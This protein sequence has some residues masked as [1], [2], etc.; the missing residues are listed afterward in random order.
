[1]KKILLL[2][3]MSA[4]LTVTA[5]AQRQTEDSFCLSDL[6]TNPTG[7]YFDVSLRGSR[8]YT[9]YNLDIFLPLG[10]NVVKAQIVT[11]SAAV[12]PATEEEVWDD[13][14]EENPCSEALHG[15]IIQQRGVPHTCL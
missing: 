1:M 2:F 14:Q 15:A 7:T 9:A 11:T 4:L 6:K 3:A 13:E 5:R 12:Y 10:I 8:I